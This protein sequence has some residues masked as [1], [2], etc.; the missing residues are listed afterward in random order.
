MILYH[1]P[2]INVVMIIQWNINSYSTQLEHLKL[3]IK[4][5]T[6]T[7]LCLQET[8]FKHSYC[9]PIKGYTVF[10]KNR[11]TQTIASGGVATYI[12]NSTPSKEIVLN[13][14]YEVVAVQTYLP[15]PIT[16]CNIYLPNSLT[17]ELTELSNIIDQLPSPFILLGDFNAHNTLWGSE[18]TNKSGRIVESMMDKFDLILLNNG[19]PTHID[20]ATGKFSAIDLSI[21]SSQIAPIFTWDTLSDPYSS[22]HIPINIILPTPFPHNHWKPLQPKWKYNEADWDLFKE[23]IDTQL[24]LLTY[25]DNIDTNITSFNNIVLSA[26][27][28]AVKKKNPPSQHCPVPWWNNECDTAIK[29]SK[30]AFYKFRRSK[31]QE[32]YINFKKLR[33]KARRTVKESKKIMDFI[34]QLPNIFIKPCRSLDKNKKN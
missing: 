33:S 5:T 30:T 19:N 3:F 1:Q 32:D 25:S 18:S 14:P 34:R 29:A 10:Y 24:E 22:D 16:I 20:P 21:S 8:N 31:S 11:T 9:A 26:A 2:M 6:P 7:L 28:I 15:F 27:E 17:V 13:S 4:D 12:H 23:T